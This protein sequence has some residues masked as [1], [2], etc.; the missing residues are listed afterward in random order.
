LQHVMQ[1]GGVIAIASQPRGPRATE[2][3]TERAGAEIKGR[4]TE[5]GYSIVRVETL[6]LEPAVVCVL[7]T[8]NGA[9][10]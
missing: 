3:G 8:F 10:N 1:P 9:A 2:G 6:P 7:A 4:L 5:A